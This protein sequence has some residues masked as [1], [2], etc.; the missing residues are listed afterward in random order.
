MNTY[1]L[2]LNYLENAPIS[3][4]APEAFMQGLPG[5]EWVCVGMCGYM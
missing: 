3:G 5:Y 4:D 1:E 2:Q